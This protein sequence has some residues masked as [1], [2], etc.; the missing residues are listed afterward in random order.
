MAK[1]SHLRGRLDPRPP[2]NPAYQEKVNQVKAG[3]QGPLVVNDS[4]PL[5]PAPAP[6][7]LTALAEAYSEARDFQ[8]RLEEHL[9]DVNLRLEAL[10]QL[11][12]ERMQNE[13]ISTLRLQN[14]QRF[15]EVFEPVAVV[16]DPQQ[17][18][19]WV[20]QQGLESLLTLPWQR[21]N[22]M[23][24]E[25]LEPGGSGLLPDG[26]EVYALSKIQRVRQ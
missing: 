22:A 12:V 2:D 15:T 18:L 25:A 5:L 9:K 11:L 17:L 24:K 26:V 16:K 6:Q 3:G 1:W 7:S 4:L 19:T 20:R 8:E 21:L 14:G 10:K 13:K 23:V